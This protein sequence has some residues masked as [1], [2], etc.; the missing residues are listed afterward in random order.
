VGGG[1]HG[2]R[3]EGDVTAGTP[4]YGR[5]GPEGRGLI[6]AIGAIFIG[7]AAHLVEAVLRERIWCVTNVFVP[8]LQ[9]GMREKTKI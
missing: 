7:Q 3:L 9:L 1:V 6:L 5:D 4:K 8:E 2:A